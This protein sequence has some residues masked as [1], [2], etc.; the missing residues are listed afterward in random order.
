[1]GQT[2]PPQFGNFSHIISFF[3]SDNDPN[4][5]SEMDIIELNDLRYHPKGSRFLS[6]FLATDFFDPL[7]HD[8][9]EH[10]KS[11]VGRENI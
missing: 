7:T 4:Y 2:P 6:D 8:H 10:W 11:G 1:M 3:L 9:K 5:P